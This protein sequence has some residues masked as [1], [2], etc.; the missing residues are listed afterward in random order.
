MAG[1]RGAKQKFHSEEGRGGPWV[2]IRSRAVGG[3]SIINIKNLKS[4]LGD[5]LQ[6]KVSM[7]SNYDVSCWDYTRGVPQAWNRKMSCDPEHRHGFWRC[8]QKHI[9][10]NHI[11]P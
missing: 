4:R 10:S 1:G 6:K 8:F 3:N 2:G 7:L 11:P 9:T 5:S